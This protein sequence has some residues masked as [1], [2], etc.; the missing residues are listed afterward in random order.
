MKKLLF[1]LLILLHGVYAQSP[2]NL[3]LLGTL[4]FPGQRLSGCWHYTSSTGKE[5]ALI[6]AENGIAIAEVS[7][8][9]P[10]HITQLPGVTSLWHEVKVLGDYAYAVSEGID[11]SNVKNGVQIIDLRFLPDSIPYRFYQG[12]GI[13]T[14]ALIH[15]HSIT[16]DGHFIYVN[17]HSITSLNRGVLII[18][19]ADPWNPVYTGAVTTAYCHDSYVRG[20]RIYTSDILDGQFSIYDLTNPASPVLLARQ[21]TTANFNHNSWLNDAGNVLFTADEVGGAPLG[22]YDIS[23]L[24]NITLIDTFYNGNFRNSE[25][26]NVRVINDY[27]INPNYGSQLTIADASRPQNIIEVGNYTTGSSLCWDADPY[28][29]SG[30]IISTDMNSGTFYVF[31]PTYQRACY[32]EGLVTDSV[33]GFP[34]NNAGVSLTAISINA[35]TDI[36]GNYKTGYADSGTYVVRYF[37]SGYNDEIRTVRLVN[38]QL[39]TMNVRLKSAGSNVPTLAVPLL[40]IYPNPVSDQLKIESLKKITGYTIFDITGKKLKDVSNLNDS[41]LTLFLSDWLAGNYTIQLTTEDGTQTRSFS[42]ARK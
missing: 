42:I 16:A 41:E 8:S 18:D 1:V 21:T 27:L 19:V 7:T 36:L 2:K 13:I 14:N 28:L 12:D 33:T 6:G 31:Q 29:P 11:S 9:T 23:D 26:H 39:T 3:N 38:G 25:V 15:A 4:T 17:G 22:S 5:Y 24:S 40:S 20:N 37:A 30:R 32:L 34:I 10:V 35:Q